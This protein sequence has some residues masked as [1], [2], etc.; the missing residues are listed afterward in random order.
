MSD[1]EGSCVSRGMLVVDATLQTIIFLMI[2]VT[3]GDWDRLG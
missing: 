2:V 1:K 3:D